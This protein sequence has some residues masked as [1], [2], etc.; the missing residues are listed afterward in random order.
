MVKYVSILIK[1]KVQQTKVA[2]ISELFGVIY[3]G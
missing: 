3:L 2:F 1:C